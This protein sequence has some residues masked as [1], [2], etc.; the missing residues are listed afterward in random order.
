[1]NAFY[2]VLQ[3]FIFDSASSRYLAPVIC[4]PY[5]VPTSTDPLH[6]KYQPYYVSLHRCQGADPTH[7]PSLRACAPSHV[8]PINVSLI[9]PNG[10]IATVVMANHTACEYA[11]VHDASVCTRY[12][13]WNQ[14]ACTCACDVR[15]RATCEK[16]RGRKWSQSTCCVC[17]NVDTCAESGGTLNEDTC[18]CTP[19]S[20]SSSTSCTPSISSSTGDSGGKRGGVSVWAVIFIVVLEFVVVVLGSWWVARVRERCRGDRGYD[21]RDRGSC[22]E[23]VVQRLNSMNYHFYRSTPSDEGNDGPYIS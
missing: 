10:A 9:E 18:V 23:F 21:G 12:E 6:H 8:Q 2:L 7:N 15:T 1:M 17:S 11:C 16:Q 14:D 19:P 3:L 5:E 22:Q 20:P 13:V 4:A